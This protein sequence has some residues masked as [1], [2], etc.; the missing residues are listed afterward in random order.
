M[1]TDGAVVAIESHASDKLKDRYLAKMIAG[2]WT[3]IMN[4]TESQTETDLAAIKTKTEKNDD[5]YLITGQKIFITWGWDHDL[6]ENI[7]HMALARLPDAL[8][9]VKG[10]S[11]FLVPKFKA[12]QDGSLGDKNDVQVVS[13]EHK[14]GIRAS[15][16]CIM[17]YGDNGGAV[18]YLV[19]KEHNGIACM[20]TMMSHARLIVGMQGV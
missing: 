20:F 2:E 10:M 17:S 15:P 4:L 12:E 8:S 14:L 7:I 5:Y 16:T 9:D 3:G 19:V 6:S 1:L 11:L 13:L 18:G